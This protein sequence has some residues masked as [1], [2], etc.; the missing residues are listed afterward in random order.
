PCDAP[1]PPAPPRL[2]RQARAVRTAP[3]RSADRRRRGPPRSRPRRPSAR[4][5]SA[6]APP[7][8]S[9]RRSRRRVPAVP[10]PHV[11]P[12]PPLAEAYA[13]AGEPDEC[14]PVSAEP[15]RVTEPGSPSVQQDGT[16]LPALI[17]S[18]SETACDSVATF[19][20]RSPAG[21]APL[22]SA[23]LAAGVRKTV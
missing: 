12:S 10:Q 18:R 8:R 7:C 9:E 20:T 17:A 22:V 14:D 13:L 5:H 19:T 6:R 21:T 11:L 3:R 4:R 1:A 23:Q 2:W 15:R 16:D